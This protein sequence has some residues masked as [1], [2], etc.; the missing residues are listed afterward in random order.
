MKEWIDFLVEEEKVN[1]DYEFT[2]PYAE[3]RD[4]E[5]DVDVGGIG[6]FK[7]KFKKQAEG[8]DL[9]DEKSEHLWKDYVETQIESLRGF[10][11]K[12]AEKR[13]IEDTDELWEE[14][15]KSVI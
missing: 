6:N 1:L 9:E 15:K 2:T 14:Y 12:E 8:E 4:G 3:L 11:E 5:G 13:G 10:F 7:Q